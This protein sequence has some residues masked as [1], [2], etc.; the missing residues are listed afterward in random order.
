MEGPQK[1]ID[2]DWKRQARLERE[3]ASAQTSRAG[4]PP[5]GRPE[6]E[7]PPQEATFLGLVQSLTL[8]A[9]VALGHQPNPDT[10]Q[11]LTDLAQAQYCIDLLGVL[12]E[13][14]RGNLTVQ[15]SRTLQ[16]TLQELRMAYVEAASGA[17]GPR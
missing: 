11:I 9:L 14:T 5:G 13:K 10:G 4:R 6:P 12:E 15:E 17:E 3:R 8:Q 16:A 7:G 2:E 1:K